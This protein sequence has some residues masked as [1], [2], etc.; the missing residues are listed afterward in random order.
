VYLSLCAKPA[1]NTVENTR[2][3]INLFIN[4]NLK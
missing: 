3:S 1:S 4:D 2:E